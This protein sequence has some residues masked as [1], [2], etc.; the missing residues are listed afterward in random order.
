M[1]ASWYY[2]SSPLFFSVLHSFLPYH[3][4]DDLWYTCYGF[5]ARFRS[6]QCKQGCFLHY[7]LLWILCSQTFKELKAKWHVMIYHV[8]AT[9]LLLYNNWDVHFDDRAFR[10]FRNGGFDC[11]DAF[12]VCY[13]LKMSEYKTYW[14]PLIIYWARLKK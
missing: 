5:G 2:Q 4:G 10:I 11:R 8:K 9:H 7:S 6:V 14:F 1:F 12:N 13:R 3:V